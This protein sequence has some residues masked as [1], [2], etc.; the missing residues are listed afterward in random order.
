MFV[1]DPV[2]LPKRY[3]PEFH[4]PSPDCLLR[5]NH[6]RIHCGWI[7]AGVDEAYSS[8]DSVSVEP[9]FWRDAGCGVAAPVADVNFQTWFCGNRIGG[10]SFRAVVH[11]FHGPV[12][13]FSSA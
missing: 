5:A 7:A 2:R 3:L 6:H 12:V 8:Q 11:V 13:S 10:L 1:A 9:R 4:V